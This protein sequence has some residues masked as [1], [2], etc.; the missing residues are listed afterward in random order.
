MVEV[1]AEGTVRYPSII[2][3][4]MQAQ[5]SLRVARHSRRPAPGV[6]SQA[7][8]VGLQGRLRVACGPPAGRLAEGG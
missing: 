4:I 7:G 2:A 3:F 6:G 5:R 1:M 8:G